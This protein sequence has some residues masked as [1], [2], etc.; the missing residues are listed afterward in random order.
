MVAERLTLEDILGNQESKFARA[1][2]KAARKLS[3]RADLEILTDLILKGD[4]E[5]AVRYLKS[6]SAIVRDGQRDAFIAA[7]DKAAGYI[8]ETINVYVSF[9]LT[10]RRAVSKLKQGGLRLVR[11]IDKE[12]KRLVMDALK[13]GVREGNNPKLIAETFKNGIG[14]T[15][16]QRAAA[17]R[18]RKI[19]EGKGRSVFDYALRPDEMDS[20]IL[21]ALRGK[22]P[23]P[24][25]LIDRAHNQYILNARAHRA[26]V[27]ARTEALRAVH[28]GAE[29]MFYQ[30]IEAGDVKKEKVRRFWLAALDARTRDTHIGL[31]GQDRD[32]D[33][34]WQTKNGNI[35][36]PG[37]PSADP[38]ETIQ[39]RC[40]LTYDVV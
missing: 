34:P 39:C 30:T 24:K 16:K 12:Q 35:M 19:L 5:G 2:L 26:K 4:S 21:S 32:L 1:F 31:N 9:D 22:K 38:A 29:E 36:Y 3:S 15:S 8:S 11:Q 37:D 10:N 25:A 13:I 18:Y 40:V 14:L 27:I 33:Q 7:A 17:A 20:E 28:E 23:M 6:L